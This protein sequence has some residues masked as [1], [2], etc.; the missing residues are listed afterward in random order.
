[1]SPSRL[2]HF[3]ED[4]LQPLFK[5]AAEFGARDQRAHIERDDAPVLQPFGN[6]AAHDA[7]G[8]ALHDGGLA[9]ARLADQHRIV[10][11]APRQH[12]DHAADL[13][14]AAD[15]RVELALARPAW[16]GRGR[17]VPALRKWPRDSAT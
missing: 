8:Q 9:H 5:L 10:L 11:G 6:V 13:L 1:M 2:L 4:R 7:L 3:L 17:S 15:H 16:S 12:L 14:V